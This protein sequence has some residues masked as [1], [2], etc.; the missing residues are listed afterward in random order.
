MS[1]ENDKKMK[2]PSKSV[3]PFASDSL[4]GE[5]TLF[6]S[7]STGDSLDA[8]LNPDY[9]RGWGIV[10][11][12]SP[13]TRQDFSASM[14]TTSQLAAYLYQQGIAEYAPEQNYFEGSVCQYQ[15]SI[16][17]ALIGAD[18]A[19]NINN[20]PSTAVDAWRNLESEESTAWDYDAKNNRVINVGEPVDGS[21]AVTKDWALA[22][23]GGDGVTI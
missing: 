23:L 16:Y 2:R 5:R 7:N 10:A 9:Q 6:G 21:D 22:N 18:D 14:F 3:K 12:D 17:I 19:P 4:S 8:N 15:G 1:W 13:P 20:E 11:Q